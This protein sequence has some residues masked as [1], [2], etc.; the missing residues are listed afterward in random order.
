L[1]STGCSPQPG[2]VTRARGCVGY[3]PQAWKGANKLAASAAEELKEGLKDVKELHLVQVVQ[4]G[5]QRVASK[6]VGALERLGDTALDLLARPTGWD[7]DQSALD[8]MAPQEVSFEK[9]FYIHGGPDY[10]EELELVGGDAAVRCARHRRKLEGSPEQ[11]HFASTEERLRLMLNLDEPMPGDG[12]DD[13]DVDEAAAAAAE[14]AAA[15]PTVASL[16][17][18]LSESMRRAEGLTLATVSAIKSE[19]MAAAD[20]DV[21]GAEALELSR[22]ALETVRAEGVRQLSEQCTLCVAHLL[23]LA[24][25]LVEVM[26]GDQPAPEAPAWPEA[27]SGKALLLRHFARHMVSTLDDVVE[28]YMTA[29]ST[30]VRILASH[31]TK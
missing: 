25:G 10:L 24:V 23:Q 13:A 5:A 14:Q 18:L 12:D 8:D 9:C 4:S 6:G 1:F 31:V 7:R 26:N 2:R 28:V 16:N 20:G 22:S 15:A 21:D 30:S 11:A 19:A 17:S 27:A 29:L 3:A